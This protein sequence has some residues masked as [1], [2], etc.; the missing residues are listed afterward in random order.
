M[1]VIIVS[2]ITPA[3]RGMLRRWF[4]EPKPNVFVG[5]VNVR[6]REKTIAY[7]RRNAPQLAMLVIFDA[8]NSQGYSILSYGETDRTFIRKCGLELILENPSFLEIK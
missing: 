3:A 8:N 4:I 6:T 7:I 1:T 2:E 5:S